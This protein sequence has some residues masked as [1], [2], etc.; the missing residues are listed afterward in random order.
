MI[1]PGGSIAYETA[2]VV[3]ALAPGELAAKVAGVYRTLTERMIANDVP[4]ALRLFV[5][6]ARPRYADIFAVLG[7]SLPAAA[8]QLGTPIDGVITEDWAEVTI[9][10]PTADGDRAFM[11]Y[12]IRGA[13]GLWRVESM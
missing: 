6:A 1:A 13:D 2:L 4:A 5:G 12:L 11:L 10:R 7:A 3:R 8:A 9:V